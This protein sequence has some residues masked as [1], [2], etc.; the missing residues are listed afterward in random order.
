MVAN[1][2]TPDRVSL[3]IV[4][5]T[6]DARGEAGSHQDLLCNADTVDNIAKRYTRANV[7][8]QNCSMG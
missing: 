3:F 4:V 5:E 2:G 1:M 8:Q 7:H 6:C